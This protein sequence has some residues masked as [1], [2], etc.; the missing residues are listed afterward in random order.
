LLVLERIAELRKRC[1]HKRETTWELQ[2]YHQH[3]GA[4][5][6]ATALGIWN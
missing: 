2:Q 5:C 4:P 1:D 6:K 3:R